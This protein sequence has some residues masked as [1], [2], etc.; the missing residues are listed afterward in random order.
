MKLKEKTLNISVVS[1]VYGVKNISINYWLLVKI[2]SVIFLSVVFIGAFFLNNYLQLEKSKD[3]LGLMTVE[4]AE[5]LVD[6]KTKI[7]KLKKFKDKINLMLG[8]ALSKNNVQLKKIYGIGAIEEEIDVKEIL[9]YSESFDESIFTEFNYTSEITLLKSSLDILYEEMKK[10]RDRLDS[11]PSIYPVKGYLTSGF[12]YR[13]SPFTGRKHLHRGID[14]TNKIGTPIIATAKGKVIEIEKNSL[15]GL[16]LIIDHGY[17]IKTQYGHLKKVL[18]K[19]NQVV[20]RNQVIAELGN[21]GR[22][23]GP[24]LH[25]QIWVDGTPVDP[26]SYIIND[27]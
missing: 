18:I 16:N 9:K 26:F 17:G 14:I 20:K 11:T 25:Y 21:S 8:E 10:N 6:F 22:T 19:E 1:D 7:N 13:I 15:W 3:K 5:N 4:L 12:G 24:H 2:M 27:N 23:T